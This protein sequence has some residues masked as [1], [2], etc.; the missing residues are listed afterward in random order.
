MAEVR[1]GLVVRAALD[2]P[3]EVC[4]VLG[5]L[6]SYPISKGSCQRKPG[7]EALIQLLI[8]VRPVISRVWRTAEALA[9]LQPN[10]RAPRT[11]L[12]EAQV[13]WFLMRDHRDMY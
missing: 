12:G 11:P 5:G 1:N 9:W 3:P 8:T 6:N 2:Q 13:P 4:C 10:S 7:F